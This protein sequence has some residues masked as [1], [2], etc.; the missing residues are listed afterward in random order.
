MKIKTEETIQIQGPYGEI[1]GVLSPC[2][3]ENITAP[4]LILAHG[5]R[6]SMDGGGR[7]IILAEMASEFCNVIRFNFTGSQILSKQIEELEAVLDYVRRN[8]SSSKIFLLGRSLGGAAALVTA[9]RYADITGLVLW[10]APNDLQTTFK[11]ALGTEAYDALS[12]GKTLYFNDERGEL[13]LTTDFVV[14]FAKYDLQ[15][16]LRNWRKRPLLI[17]HGEKDETVAV[18]QARLSFALA[19]VPKKLIVISGSDHSFTNHGN[20]AAAEVV[21][22]LRNRL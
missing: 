10:A 11:K 12:S 21:N 6:G 17:I 5:F 20:K 8:F 19:G 1:N 13:A 16:I 3:E 2:A 15:E 7:A 22:W 9:A 14:D 18:E 4:V